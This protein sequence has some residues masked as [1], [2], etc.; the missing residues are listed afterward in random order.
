MVRGI[1]KISQISK[2]N[3][4]KYPLIAFFLI[5][6]FLYSSLVKAESYAVAS[7]HHL[8]TDIGM[9]VLNEG[10]NA[11]DA[12]VAVAFALAVV[13][14]SAG[15][16]GGGGF[17]LIH[18]AEKNE[19]FSI[20][21]RE[22]SPIKS[23]EKMFQD[24]SG[25]VIKGLSLNSILASGVP[26]TVS[27][28][29][30]ASEKYGTIDIKDL[31]SPSI[32]LARKGFVLSEFQAKNLNKYK[33]K[34]SKNEEA[35]KIFTRPNG[36][37]EGDILVQTN[38]ANTLERISQY[39]EEEFYSGE[40]AKKISGFFQINGG[41]LSL[42]DLNQYKLRILQPVCGSYRHYVI[43]SMAP[44]SSGGIALVQ[45]LN[46]LENIDLRKLEHNS[47]EYLSL[48]ISTMD[49]AYKD[50]AEYLG[51]PDYFKVPQDKLTSKKYADEIFK[52]IQEK[53]L[54]SKTDVNVY[55]GEETTHFSIVDK[56]GNAVSNTYT[57]NTAYGSGI[58][59]TGTGILMNNEMDDFSS[60][61]GYPNA[62]GL[63]GSKANK[64][65]PKKTPLSSM[66]PVIVL[67]H[68][69]PYLI[70][71]SPGGSTIITSVLQE[72]LNVLDFQM[73]LE[74]SSKKSRIH[75]Q[76]LPDVLFHEQLDNSLI[77]SLKKDKK[78]INRKLGEVHSILLKKDGIEAFSDKRRP[79]GK[80]SSIY[81]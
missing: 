47:E 37:S 48:L 38:L 41:I 64:I 32:E 63:V 9:K 56:W 59:P 20:D 7:R 17:M 78:L 29:F 26:G 8:A 45:I 68:E 67:H 77:K 30:Y 25:K 40:T 24:K 16:L 4:S 70:T 76:H 81:K 34:F 46:V 35:K 66:S 44:P 27:G 3:I 13:N 79:D 58:I 2:I 49:Y 31:I 11:I 28:M 71:G 10:G 60:K 65:E 54:P 18:L 57:L 62:Y 1:L 22:R 53:K 5:L 69:K 72:I 51:D 6:L 23:F 75:F 39:G 52:Q 12:A 74:E 33:Q 50:R 19:T 73:S 80:A 55:E 42:E 21:Y 14:P 15:N 43:C 36:F 61:P